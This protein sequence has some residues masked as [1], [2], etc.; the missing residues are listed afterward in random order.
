[1]WCGAKA[2]EEMGARRPRRRATKSGKNNKQGASMEKSGMVVKQHHRT[3]AKSSLQGEQVAT[4]VS[5]FLVYYDE[6]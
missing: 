5:S 3:K 6:K 1:M 4:S 2:T